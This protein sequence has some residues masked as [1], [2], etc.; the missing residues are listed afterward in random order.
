MEDG[1]PAQLL[2]TEST[3]ENPFLKT[4]PISTKAKL[5]HAVS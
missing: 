5:T 1:G 3:Y 4:A 2:D